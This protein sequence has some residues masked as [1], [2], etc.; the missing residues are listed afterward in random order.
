MDPT[1][2]QRTA[3]LQHAG[4]ARWAYNW[5]LSRKIEAYKATG[6]SPSAIDLHRELNVLK[7]IPKEQGGVPWMY[8]ASKCAPQE[9]LRNLDA[10][11]ANFFRRCKAGS[12]PGFPRFKSKH[13]GIGSFKFSGVKADAVEDAV[14]WL[15][16]IG[17][18]RLKEHG[19]LP[20]SGVKVLSVTV[21]EKAGHW[22]A[23]VQIEQEI[24]PKVL[25]AHVLGVDV[26]ISNL[27]ATSDGE[28]FDNP[29][30]LRRMELKLRRLNKSLSRKKKGSRNRAKAVKRVAR[31]HYRI[32]CVRKDA[33]HKVTTAIAKQASTI[34]IESL[35]VAGMVKN[36]CLAK[37]VSD[38]SMSEVHRQL[39]YKVKWNGGTLIKADRWFPSS[40]TCSDCGLLM[41]DLPLSVR[42]WT[43]PNCGVV[44]DRDVNAACNLKK[45]A[46]SSPVTACGESSSGPEYRT[47]LD[48]IKQEP[49]CVVINA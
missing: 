7:G 32:A 3:F 22:F 28:L 10:A 5:G 16:R 27:A 37:A 35:N 18:V 12:K 13:R 4:A 41:D 9:A 49:S 1:N 8:D 19:Y 33:I 17:S 47:K 21:S 30:A 26:G 14:I 2:E 42:E 48:S 36:H 11:Y 20:T 31:L 6:K 24:Q 44:H 43:C 46:G 15:P 39:E 29:R 40:K 34:V 38:A 45:L 25:P 23:S